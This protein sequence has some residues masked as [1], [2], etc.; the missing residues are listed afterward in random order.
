MPVETKKLDKNNML[1]IEDGYGKS[2]VFKL[3]ESDN[4]SIIKYSSLQEGV[5]AVLV[6][7]FLNK[8]LTNEKVII[9][10]KEYNYYVPRVNLGKDEDGNVFQQQE[11]LENLQPKI[12]NRKIQG[13]AR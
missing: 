3:E 4:T 12:N 13:I 9:D 10:G 11:F 7:L 1:K 6:S 8:I 5:N 2:Q